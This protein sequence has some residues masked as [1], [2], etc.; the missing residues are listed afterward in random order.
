MWILKRIIIVV[1][2]I[3]IMTMKRLK[4]LSNAKKNQSGRHSPQFSERTTTT[5]ANFGSAAAAY[6]ERQYIA[7]R[8]V[9]YPISQSM[10]PGGICKEPESILIICLYVSI[11]IGLN[12]TSWIALL[13]S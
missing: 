12:R 3:K 6:V 10:Y 9:I 5:G 8:T 1:V 13:H 11:V 4:K 7:V 2:R